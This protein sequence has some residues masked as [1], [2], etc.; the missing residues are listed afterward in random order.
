MARLT[1]SYLLQQDLSILKEEI[2][3]MGRG[4][5]P[6]ITF[7]TL[8]NVVDKGLYNK[9]FVQELVCAICLTLKKEGLQKFSILDFFRGCSNLKN[10]LQE[11]ANIAQ[12]R[13]SSISLEK[14]K[15]LKTHSYLESAKRVPD[16]SLAGIISRLDYQVS[17][18]IDEIDRIEESIKSLNILML[19]SSPQKKDLRLR[20]KQIKSKIASNQ[21]AKLAPLYLSAISRSH[22]SSII[23]EEEQEETNDSNSGLRYRTASSPNALYLNDKISTGGC[24]SETTSN[25]EYTNDIDEIKFTNTQIMSL[26]TRKNS[27]N[28]SRKSDNESYLNKPGFVNSRNNLSMSRFVS[29]SSFKSSFI[30]TQAQSPKNYSVSEF[31]ANTED[32]LAR[33]GVSGNPINTLDVVEYWKDE[34]I[35]SISRQLSYARKELKVKNTLRNE[36]NLHTHE[37]EQ[38]IRR[39]INEIN[40]LNSQLIQAKQNKFVADYKEHKCEDAYAEIMD[41]T[42]SV[43][44]S[45]VTE[46]LKLSEE[47]SLQANEIDYWRN[48]VN[49]QEKLSETLIESQQVDDKK[50]FL[51]TYNSSR[52]E[53]FQDL[54]RGVFFT[55]H[56]NDEELELQSELQ[57]QKPK[58]TIFGRKGDIESKLSSKDN[59]FAN[60]SYL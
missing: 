39:L 37:N 33:K 13:F 4:V 32:L 42:G 1:R 43:I 10:E 50:G 34:S 31:D 47:V 59:Q 20:A 19:P 5:K 24:S 23:Q 54:I 46:N 6:N 16:A 29:T 58:I 45:L 18:Q 55:C 8:S 2:L 30:N 17:L 21:K 53:Y 11:K 44:K 52:A 15:A 14:D 26:G 12:A 40:K 60:F 22:K 51:N 48:Q 25:I 28:L 38:E 36:P 27:S 35:K 56:T 3:Q 57:L 9:Q 49:K 41:Q 7:Q